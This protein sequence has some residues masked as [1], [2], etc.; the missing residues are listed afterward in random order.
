MQVYDPLFIL[1]FSSHCLSNG[2]IE[3]LEFASFGLLALTFLSL[4]SSDGHTRKLG[5]E[6]LGIFRSSLE[7]M[8]SKPFPVSLAFASVVILCDCMRLSWVIAVSNF[9]HRCWRG[10]RR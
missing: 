4:S 8:S 5:Y 9:K 10:F 3:P 1:R 2:Y 6:V 7:V